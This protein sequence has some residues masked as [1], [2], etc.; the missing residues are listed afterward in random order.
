MGA[1]LHSV[2]WMGLWKSLG[3]VQE[4]GMSLFLSA[5]ELVPFKKPADKKGNKK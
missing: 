3:R 1:F 4:E 5:E 2:F